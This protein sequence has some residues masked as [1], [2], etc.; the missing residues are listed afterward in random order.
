MYYDIK[1][2]GMRIKEMRKKAGL[3]QEKLAEKMNLSTNMISKMEQGV[4]G[5]T[6][7]NIGIIAEILNT[8]VDYLAY[9]RSVMVVPEE[10]RS[11]FEAM[12]V[13]YNNK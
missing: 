9:G 7:D 5:T 3:T 11:A 4:S 13:G 12:I 6:L 8:T 10:L 2:S 1:E